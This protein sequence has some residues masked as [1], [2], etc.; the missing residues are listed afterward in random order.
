MRARLVVGDEDCGV[1][2]KNVAISLSDSLKKSLSEYMAGPDVTDNGADSAVIV[3]EAV[4]EVAGAIA[5]R[6]GASVRRR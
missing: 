1:G 6:R 3:N 2:V 5:A 4:D